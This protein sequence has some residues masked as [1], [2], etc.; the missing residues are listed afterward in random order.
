MAAGVLFIKLILKWQF[1]NKANCC[2]R[3]IAISSLVIGVYIKTDAVAP[4]LHS[5]AQPVPVKHFDF[6]NSCIPIF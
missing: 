1:V 2:G 4:I 6:G 3:D 5:G